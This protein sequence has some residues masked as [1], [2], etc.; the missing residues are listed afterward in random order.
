MKNTRVASTYNSR[1]ENV[2]IHLIVSL[3]IQ[4]QKWELRAR[5]SVSSIVSHETIDFWGKNA[6]KSKKVLQEITNLYIID[7]GTA[8]MH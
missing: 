3:S 8:V 5:T 1:Q 2:D 4:S 6:K 7:G